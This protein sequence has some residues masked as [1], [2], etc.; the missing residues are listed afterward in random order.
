MR[1]FAIGFMAVLTLAGCN[2]YK[3]LQVFMAFNDHPVVSQAGRIPATRQDMLSL[4]QQPG[5]ITP[6][7]GGRSQCFDYELE[8]D[9]ERM[10]YFVTF[11]DTGIVNNS[12]YM[13]CSTAQAE[14]Y[15]R[16]NALP[17]YRNT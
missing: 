9:G 4:A 3:G 15:L 2:T 14:G 10:P 12:G 5:R 1:T 7:R 6:I 17:T 11:T 8:S 13:S 16:S